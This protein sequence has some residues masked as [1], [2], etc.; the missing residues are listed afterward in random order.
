LPQRMS[1]LMAQSGRNETSA[2]CP[3]SGA[4]R[5]SVSDRRIIAIYEYTLSYWLFR[6]ENVGSQFLS[7]RQ[8][9]FA[10]HSPRS[11]RGEH[12]K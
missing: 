8:R 6:V 7:L 1:P 4:K 9:L 12:P 3:L 11:Q 10:R 2:I 5:T